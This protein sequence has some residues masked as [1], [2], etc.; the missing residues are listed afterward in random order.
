MAGCYSVVNARL[1]S[2]FIEPNIGDTAI[3]LSDAEGQL[4]AA[5]RDRDIS[6]RINLRR[7]PPTDGPARAIIFY[8]DV[9]IK[10]S[11]CCWE[12]V[13]LYSQKDSCGGLSLV[14][15]WLCGFTRTHTM[16]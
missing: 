3:A 7:F 13:P 16:V 9:G 4:A 12:K 11:I 15:Q 5:M 2:L 14:D 8:I 1:W 6:L 10:N